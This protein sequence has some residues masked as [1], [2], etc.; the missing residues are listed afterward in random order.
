MRVL[1]ILFILFG[2][3]FSSLS[4]WY[5]N[6]NEG[7]SVAKEKGKLV[8]VYFYEEGCTYCKYMEEVVFL[9]P[10]V[11]SLMEKGYVVVPIDVE[12]IPTDLDRRFRAV[13]TP[14]FMVYDPFSDRV[15]LQIFGMQEADQFLY[16]LEKACKNTERC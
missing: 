3:N 2:L 7:V 11:S 12:D 16:L 5:P 1:L 13:G 15:A 9:E 8:L 14:T 6:F 10:E 4:R